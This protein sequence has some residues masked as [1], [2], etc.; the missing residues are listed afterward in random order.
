MGTF[1]YLSIN[2]STRAFTSWAYIKKGCYYKPFMYT[3]DNTYSSLESDLSSH[4]F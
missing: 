2:I 3:L 4:F 1:T